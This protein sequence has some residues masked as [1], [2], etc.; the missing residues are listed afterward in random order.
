[1]DTFQFVLALDLGMTLEQ[2]AAMPRREYLAWQA[3]YTYRKAMADF[4]RRTNGG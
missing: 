3:F 4:E 2:L 1:M